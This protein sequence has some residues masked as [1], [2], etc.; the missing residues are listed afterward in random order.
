MSV[1]GYMNFQLEDAYELT[2]VDGKRVEEKIGDVF[3]RCN[4]VLFVREHTS[5]DSS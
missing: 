2:I 4:N 3:I 5:N 1:D